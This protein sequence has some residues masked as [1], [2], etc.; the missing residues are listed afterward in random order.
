MTVV[1]SASTANPRVKILALSGRL[2]VETEGQVQPRLMEAITQSPQGLILDL[3][4][5]TFVSSAGLRMLI[6]VYK[7]AATSG[8]KLAM[9]R[10]SPETYKLFKLA[11]LDLTF[12]VFE[13]EADAVMAIC[14]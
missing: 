4:A 9:I 14:P 12:N 3:K 8:T 10:P 6:M 13:N 7:N 2:S 11:A 5:V 1:L